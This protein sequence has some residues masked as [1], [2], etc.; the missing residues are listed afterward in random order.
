MVVL[1]MQ[2]TDTGKLDLIPEF[3][4]QFGDIAKACRQLALCIK[5]QPGASKRPGPR[6]IVP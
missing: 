4:S 3:V 6:V 1:P 2:M 5:C